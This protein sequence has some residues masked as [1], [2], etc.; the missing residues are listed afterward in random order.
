[1][2]VEAAFFLQVGN[3]MA[4][5]IP[6]DLHRS[7]SGTLYCIAELPAFA[8]FGARYQ[9]L[10]TSMKSALKIP[11]DKNNSTKRWFAPIA[12]SRLKGLKECERIWNSYKK[13]NRD[14]SPRR[15]AV[16]ARA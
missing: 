15:P 4:S 2:F 16:C 10:W 11:L 8:V 6:F 1:Q 9:K 7:G 12:S 14:F 13:T 5:A 3:I